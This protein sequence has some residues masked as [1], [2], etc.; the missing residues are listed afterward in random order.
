MKLQK[1]TN[2]IT[3]LLF[4][5]L[6]AFTSRS[7]AQT[8]TPADGAKGV[9]KTNSAVSWT[10][11]GSGT[12]DVEFNGTDNTYTSS[13][14]SS[15][16]TTALTFAHGQTLSYNTTYYWQV[17]DN[18]GPGAWQQFSFTTEFSLTAPTNGLTG[19]A[20]QPTFSWAATA[21]N[22][23][24]KISTHSDMSSPV[25]TKTGITTNTG[26]TLS[27]ANKLNNNTTYYWQVTDAN[28]NTSEIFSFTT[29]PAVTINLVNP[30]AGSTVYT[31]STMF[32]W[33]INQAV[34][35]MKFEVQIVAKTSSPT[36]AEWAS[37]TLTTTTS[38][39]YHTF[40]LNGGTQYYWRIVLLNSSDEVIGYSSE[41]TFTTSGGASVTVTPSYPTGGV[42]V[43]TNTPT[44]YW[45]VN[46]YAPGVTYD[47]KYSKSS[48]T[49]GGVLNSSVTDVTGITN[50]YKQIPASGSLTPGTNYY[51]QV[52]AHYGTSTGTWSAVQNFVTSGSTT[53]IVP[54]ASYPTGGVTVYTVSPTLYWYVGGSSSG[55]T[56]EIDYG[57]SVDGT[58]D[59]TG[60]SNLYY[61]LSGLTPGTTYQWRVRS[62]NG[63]TTS[64]W[65]STETFKVSGGV[66]SSST[67]ATWPLNNPTMYTQKPTLYWYLNGSSLGLT[68][69]KI[70]YSTTDKGGAATWGAFTTAGSPDATD[71]EV[72]VN[73]V[74]TTYWTATVNLTYGQK[75]YWAV[76]SWDGST[77]GTYSA[78][79]FTI[80]GGS[81][82]GSV[83]LSYP[84]GGA[85]I[86]TKSP[87]LDW[88][89]TG[90]TF[91]ITGYVVEYSNDGG[92]TWTQKASALTSTATSVALSGLTPGATYTWKVRAKYSTTYSSYSTPETFVVAPG[93]ST[94]VP[95]VGGPNNVT[96]NTSNAEVSWIIPAKPQGNLT[97]ELVFADNAEMQNAKTITSN[98]PHSE[99]SNLQSN[100]N[101]FWKVRSKNNNGDYS[102]YS[103]T[104]AFKTDDKITSV[105]GKDDIIPTK[106]E[107]EQNYPNP[108]NPSTTIKF[109]LP[110]TEYVT[111]KV[112]NI[113]GKEIAVLANGQF[114]AGGHSIIWNGKDSNGVNVASGI[115]LYRVVAGNNRIT[116]KM[117]LL[118]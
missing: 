118:K 48:G 68:G 43:Y 2:F 65:S 63:T 93:A 67:V 90:S 94:I 78:G 57:T 52:R 89:F 83:V 8:P 113:L 54:T 102:S 25:V 58:A 64:A 23:T 53:P 81:S 109:S 20:I 95:I 44:L 16:A 45:Y 115:Y 35:S 19:V 41:A 22:Y 108:F 100:M 92:T 91:G 117:L 29:I 98:V 56:Y 42:K 37:S 114:N 47:V 75:Y 105:G 104:G 84:I 107:V 116:K 50:L 51:W 7:F 34:G 86:T 66:T 71:S 69:Y 33:S 26:Y 30:A 82:S 9:A 17:R 110:Q 61:A 70:K 39:L 60:V 112:Y 40:A 111:I 6:L 62:N 46:Q 12:F 55:L 103:N 88:Y 59:I 11:F 10:T 96:I 4:V 36:A 32:T 5:V 72:T 28:S 49:A 87:T 3:T 101:Y 15:T 24:L 97:Y 77:A 14:S 21:A 80:A 1:L 73:S 38:S 79:D 27:E 18:S 99:V 13:I 76:A 106:F 85:T 31:T 74:S